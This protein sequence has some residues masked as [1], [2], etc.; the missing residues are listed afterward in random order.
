MK[1]CFKCGIE[2]EL[3]EFYKH[4]QMKDGHLNKCKIC[5]RKDSNNNRDKKCNDPIFQES[6]RIRGREKYYRLNYV[7]RLYKKRPRREHIKNIFNISINKEEEMHHWDYNNQF[8]C[9]I[10]NRRL[11]RKFHVMVKLNDDNIFYYNNDIINTKEQHQKILEQINLKFN[12][13]SRIIYCE[14]GKQPYTKTVLPKDWGVYKNKNKFM[15]RITRNYINKIIGYYHTKEEAIIERDN[16][17]NL[18]DI[19]TF[20]KIDVIK[21]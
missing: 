15:V 21:N 4:P 18:I 13:N 12:L 3:D 1:K 11:H 8:S 19:P 17:I 9:F 7:E 14:M 10:I 5:T 2:K 16:Y 6:E 20:L